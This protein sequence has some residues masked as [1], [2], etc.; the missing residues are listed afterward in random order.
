MGALYRSDVGED[1]QPADANEW[2]LREVSEVCEGF[3]FVD[4]LPTIRPLVKSLTPQYTP[5]VLGIEKVFDMKKGDV[6]LLDP[7]VTLS[8]RLL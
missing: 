7:R 5:T 8:K 4:S 1:D 6:G 3:H 2:R